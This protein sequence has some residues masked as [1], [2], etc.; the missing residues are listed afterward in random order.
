[1]CGGGEML[2]QASERGAVL[3]VAH[4][5]RTVYCSPE[6]R[7]GETDRFARK[8]AAS[9]GTDMVEATVNLMHGMAFELGWAVDGGTARWANS[10]KACVWRPMGA[11]G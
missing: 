10:G 2:E 4:G 3:S 8:A 1:M 5:G 6:A 11:R 7:F 9:R